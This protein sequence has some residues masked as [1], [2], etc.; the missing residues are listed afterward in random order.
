MAQNGISTLQYKRDRQDQKLTLA[1]NDR[2]A[3]NGNTP[4]RY[5]VTSADATELPTRYASNDNT[6]SSIIDNPN[7]GGL[8]TGRPFAP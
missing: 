4:G 3:V 7:T 6:H 5:A 2:T 8:K 1:G